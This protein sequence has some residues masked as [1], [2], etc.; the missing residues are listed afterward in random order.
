MMST[1]KALCNIK[2]LSEAKVLKLREVAQKIE[3]IQC[4]MFFTYKFFRFWF[5]IRYCNYGKT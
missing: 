5:Y 4:L 1:T 2:G 3:S